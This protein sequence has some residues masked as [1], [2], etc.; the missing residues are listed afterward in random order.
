MAEVQTYSWADKSIAPVTVD[1]TVFGD[2]IRRRLLREAVLMYEARR[3]VGTNSTKTRAKV[4]G[5]TIKPWRQK[6][7]GRAR[8]G[9][10]KSPIWRGGGVTHGPH[11]RDYSYSLPRKALR[12]ALCSALLAKLRD[13]EVLGI[14][15]IE[16]EAP[17]TQRVA[18]VLA[19]LKIDGTALIVLPE[20]DEAAYKSGRNIARTQVCIAAEVNAYD[21][22]KCKR[23]IVVGDALERIRERVA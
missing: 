14:D 6:G 23:L 15:M 13:N 18:E 22:L 17:K 5:S 9:T 1:E 10:R 3:R 11:P 4:R 16:L 8:A 21:V 12:V 19:A 20:A 7:T 2:R